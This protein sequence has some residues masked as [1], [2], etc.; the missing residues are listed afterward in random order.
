MTRAPAVI[1]LLAALAA[2]GCGK[3]APSTSTDNASSASSPAAAAEL[4]PTTPEPTG[5][6]GKLTWAVYRD[7]QTLDPIQAFDYPENTVDTVLCESLLRQNPDGSLTAGL[8]AMPERPDARTVVLKLS[9]IH[10]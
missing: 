3:A 7:V 9:L 6:A 8:S 1:A 10:I 2:T 5:E 4:S